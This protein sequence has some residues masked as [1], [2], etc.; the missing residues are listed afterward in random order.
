MSRHWCGRVVFAKEAIERI[1]D[2]DTMKFVDFIKQNRV[3]VLIGFIMGCSYGLV[4]GLMDAYQHSVSIV[5]K[6][7][8]MGGTWIGS[9]QK[10]ISAQVITVE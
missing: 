10:C 9:E 8:A 6:C 1:R 4:S 3:L 5:K 2:Y 7:E